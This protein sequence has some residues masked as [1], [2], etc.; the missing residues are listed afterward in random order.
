MSSEADDVC[1]DAHNANAG[2]RERLHDKFRLAN[3]GRDGMSAGR[4]G[5]SAGRDG[6]SARCIAGLRHHSAE[7]HHISTH[8]QPDRSDRK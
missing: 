8:S 7:L 1:S 3:A 5:T 2:V 4:D 6:T